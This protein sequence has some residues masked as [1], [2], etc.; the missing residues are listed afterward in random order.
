MKGILKYP[1]E[2]AESG[3]DDLLRVLL[4]FDIF[5]YPLT[6]A[7]IRQYMAEP[8]ANGNFDDWISQLLRD[9]RIF[10]HN[11]FYSAQD[12]PLLSLRR[13]QGN[14]RAEKLLRKANK[15]GRFL[16]R[17]PFVKGVGISGSLSKNF[18]DEKADIDFFIITKSNRLWLA[19]TFMHCFKKF[20]FLTGRQHYYCMN[21]YIDE[22]TMLIDEKNI[23]TAIEIK[24]LIPV[25]GT[26]TL[27]HFI[28]ENEWTDSWLPAFPLRTQWQPDPARSMFKRLVEWL[29]NGSA[30]EKLDNFLFRITKRR[31][32]QKIKS[33]KKNGKGLPMD[34]DTGKHFARSNPGAF[35]EKVLQAYQEKL[36]EYELV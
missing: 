30:G 20:T 5:H 27:N 17:F 23:F 21:Y 15:I 36:R 11:G 35:R 10:F 28:S 9:R 8:A 16:Y 7:E 6:G 12:N 22:Q 2:P 3:M 14:E 29:F 25:S 18:A 26:Q 31:W 13:K 1:T 32:E 4:Y 19:R 33:G 34:L 24:T